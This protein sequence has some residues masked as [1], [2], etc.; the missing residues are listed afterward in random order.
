MMLDQVPNKKRHSTACD[1]LGGQ[2]WVD[3]GPALVAARARA[4][5]VVAAARRNADGTHA[6]AVLAVLEPPARGRRA[7][8]DR[9]T[10]EATFLLERFIRENPAEW[11]WLH[12]RWTVPAA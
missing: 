11:L 4:P 5:L 9:A 8:A 10:V 12:R 3:R 7:W 6:M 1:F 2:A